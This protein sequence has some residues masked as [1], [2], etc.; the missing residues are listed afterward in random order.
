MDNEGKKLARYDSLVVLRLFRLHETMLVL[1]FSSTAKIL[2]I[3]CIFH[4]CYIDAPDDLPRAAR[5]VNHF[6]L[7]GC[8]C[9]EGK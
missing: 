8:F 6:S 9:L 1:G 4:Y 2:G 5:L 3:V 7:V